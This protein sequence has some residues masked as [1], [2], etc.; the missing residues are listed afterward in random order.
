MAQEQIF[1][2]EVKNPNGMSIHDKLVTK[3]GYACR[4]LYLNSVD[5]GTTIA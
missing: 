4:K 1:L 2:M 3:V 5:M